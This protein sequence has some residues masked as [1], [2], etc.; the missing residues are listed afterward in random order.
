MSKRA[1]AFDTVIVGWLALMA[2]IGTTAVWLVTAAYEQA[3]ASVLIDPPRQVGH[4][5]PQLAVDRHVAHRQV[6]NPSDV[7]RL[8]DG[9]V[10]FLGEVDHSLVGAGFVEQPHRGARCGTKLALAEV[11]F[12]AQTDEQNA[13]GERSANVMQQ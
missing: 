1:F 5:H 6:A 9:N 7:Q 12:F 11:S 4:G 3:E 8:A 13:V 2:A 10:A